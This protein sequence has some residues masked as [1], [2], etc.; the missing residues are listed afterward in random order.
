MRARVI[1]VHDEPGFAGQLSAALEAAGHSVTTFPDPLLAWD[2]LDNK[3]PCDVLI[4]RIEFQPGRS[5]GVALARLARSTH[6]DIRI[7]F[8][9]LPEHAPHADGIGAFMSLPVTVADVVRS[10]ERL[11]E[12]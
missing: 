12:T 11:L 4:T 1:V 2:S 7:L 3:H 8:T 10:V 9:A 6:P 5:N